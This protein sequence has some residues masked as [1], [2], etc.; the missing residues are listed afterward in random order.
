MSWVKPTTTTD[1]MLWSWSGGSVLEN[2][3]MI[4]DNCNSKPMN[5]MLLTK[6]GNIRKLQEL[7][8]PNPESWKKFLLTKSKWLLREHNK[9]QG[10]FPTLEYPKLFPWTRNGR[11]HRKPVLSPWSYPQSAQ[12]V[13]VLSLPRLW[14]IIAFRKIKSIVQGK[15]NDGVRRP[16]QWPNTSLALTIIS[17]QKNSHFEILAGRCH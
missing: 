17:H 11:H 4:L 7:K 6:S 1:N 10:T 3:A 16:A 14:K 13:T 9:L 5:T 8:T 12:K 15:K 2:K